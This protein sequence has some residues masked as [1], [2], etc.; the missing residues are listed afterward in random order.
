[1]TADNDQF[2]DYEP[3]QYVIVAGEKIK[4]SDV[5]FVDIEE[6]FQGRDLLTFKYRGKQYQSY[7]IRS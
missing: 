6:D 4:A 2:L 1:M 3:P 5:E 7:I